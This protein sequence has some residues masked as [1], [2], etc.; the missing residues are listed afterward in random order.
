MASWNDQSPTPDI[1]PKMT[2]EEAKR[3]FK[4]HGIDE[5]IPNPKLLPHMIRDSEVPSLVVNEEHAQESQS[6]RLAKQEDLEEKRKMTKFIAGAA[7]V[8]AAVT[9]AGKVVVDYN[10]SHPLRPNT[11]TKID[12]PHLVNSGVNQQGKIVFFE[13]K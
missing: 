3:V 12:R 1:K 4:E 13:D 7:A 8:A 9:A 11:P 2:L 6:R 5:D 10:R